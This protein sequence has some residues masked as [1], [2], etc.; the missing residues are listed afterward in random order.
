MRSDCV[1]PKSFITWCA[2]PASQPG[3]GQCAPK[4]EQLLPLFLFSRIRV[5]LQTS[6]SI[7]STPTILLCVALP[8]LYTTGVSELFL[9]SGLRL[10]YLWCFIISKQQSLTSFFRKWEQNT[11]SIPRYYYILDMG[12]FQEITCLSMEK[13]AEVIELVQIVYFLL[14]FPDCWEENL[15]N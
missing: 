7:K 9:A 13:Y 6:A 8:L 11:H 3:R 14:E 4:T 10:C 1:Q 2:G 12:A 5:V 15:R